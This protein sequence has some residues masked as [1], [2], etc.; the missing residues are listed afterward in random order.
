MRIVLVT[1]A[2][3]QT[4]SSAA[5]PDRLWYLFLVEPLFDFSPPPPPPPRHVPVS[6]G[7]E[8]V[9]VLWQLQTSHKQF[10]PRLGSAIARVSCSPDDSCFTVSLQ[11]N[12]KM[13]VSGNSMKKKKYD[14]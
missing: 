2:S 10:R 6:G 8:G 7:E 14:H 3:H 11:N 5:K 4:V 12:G 1:C 13:D 9:L